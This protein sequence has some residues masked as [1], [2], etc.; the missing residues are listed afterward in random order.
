MKTILFVAL[1]IL[2]IVVIFFFGTFKKEGFKSKRIPKII[3]TFWDSDDIPEIVQKCIETWK[4]TNPEYKINIVSKN[5]IHLFLP[6]GEEIFSMPHCKDSMQR[7]SDF[8]RL[9]LLYHYGGFWIDAS[10]ILN[11]SLDYFLQIQEEKGC[12]FLGYYL[13]GF[14]TREHYP[15]IESWFLV[16]V[17]KSI[18][19]KLWLQCFSIINEH[20]TLDEYMDWVKEERVDIQKINAPKYLTIHVACQHM[21]QKLLTRNQMGRLLYLEKAEDGPL[22]YLN[23]NDWNSKQGLTKTC[24][25]PSLKTLVFKM[26]S[27]ERREIEKDEHLASCLFSDTMV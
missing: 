8:I 27:I 6:D 16:A 7:S 26:R 12:D 17:P 14:T 21:L 20:E 3:W 1:A 11:G 15:V 13:D 24:E 5:N 22:K 25:D 9:Q 4:R 10:T 19:I 2:I 23:E 18:V